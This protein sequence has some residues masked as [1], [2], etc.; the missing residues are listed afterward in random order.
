MCSPQL[1]FSYC[2]SF[3]GPGSACSHH[4]LPETLLCKPNSICP[5]G[6]Q[7]QQVHKELW[8]LLVFPHIICYISTL[9]SV[10]VVLQWK[11]GSCRNP[12]GWIQETLPKCEWHIPITLWMR[13]MIQTNHMNWYILAPLWSFTQDPSGVPHE[14]EPLCVL[15]FYVHESRQRS[16]CGRKL[17]EAMMQVSDSL[18]SLQSD[19]GW[20]ALREAVGVCNFIILL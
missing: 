13:A 1:F 18:V 5:E 15:D 9:H 10:H 19:F 14:V 17:F 3:P 7:L 2:V 16:G 4:H 12:K 20:F 6:H 8:N 11:G